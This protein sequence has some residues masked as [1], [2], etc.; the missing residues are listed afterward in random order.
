[1]P[2]LFEPEVL[3]VDMEEAAP[4]TSELFRGNTVSRVARF[5]W[6]T[7]NKNVNESNSFGSHLNMSPHQVVVHVHD[8]EVQKG[9]ETVQPRVLKGEQI[10]L[11]SCPVVPGLPIWTEDS[12]VALVF[13]FHPAPQVLQ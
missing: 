13:E 3:G 6:H 4:P 5:L 1:M 9:G 11:Q 2:G 8:C 7:V 10:I 12:D